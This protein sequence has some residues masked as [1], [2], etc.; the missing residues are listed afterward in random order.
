MIVTM[1]LIAPMIGEPPARWMAEIASVRAAPV[2]SAS[3]G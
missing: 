1:M 3:G 2:C